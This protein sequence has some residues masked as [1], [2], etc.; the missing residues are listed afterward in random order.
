MA[1]G[2]GPRPSP[3]SYADVSVGQRVTESTDCNLL[4][5]LIPSVKEKS[6]IE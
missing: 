4:P 2:H 6:S 5:L 3:S 1:G